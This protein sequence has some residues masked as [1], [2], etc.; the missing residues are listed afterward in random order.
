M[1]N[2]DDK[3]AELQAIGESAAKAL[4]EMVAAVQCDYDR[5]RELGETPVGELDTDELEE[6]AEL[7]EAAGECES[8]DDAHERIQEDPLSIELS[9]TWNVCSTPVADKAIILLGTGG[10]AVRIVCELDSYMQ[11]Q[12][13]WIEAQDWFQPWTEYLGNAI[14]RG[15]LLGYCSHFCFGEG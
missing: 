13:A 3:Y 10:P 12:H 11:P 2:Q 7:K 8:E 9:G 1:S 15:D 4:A 6:L 14:S 5:L